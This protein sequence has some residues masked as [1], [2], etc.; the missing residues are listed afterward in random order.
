MDQTSDLFDD[1]LTDYDEPPEDSDELSDPVDGFSDNEEQHREDGPVE[2]ALLN[3]ISDS[4]SSDIDISSE[5]TENEHSGGVLLAQESE[6]A[7]YPIEDANAA[8]HESEPVQEQAQEEEDVQ[9]DSDD[10]LIDDMLDVEMDDPVWRAPL[11]YDISWSKSKA[12][13]FV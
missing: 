2:N 10:M 1:E 12:T 5:E 4:P 6:Q 8:V 7:D 11:L 3:Q 9:E 13:Q